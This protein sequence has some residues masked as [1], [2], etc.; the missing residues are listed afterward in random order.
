MQVYDLVLSWDWRY[1]EDFVMYVE[2][3]CRSRGLTFNQITRT[4]L[5]ETLTCLYSG[6]MTFRALLDRAADDL[7]FEPLRRFAQEHNLLRINPAEKSHWAEDK[8]TMHLELIQAGV[9]TPYTILLASF[10]HEPLLPAMDL[11]PLGTKFVVKP[12]VG[13]GGEGVRMN[14]T[15]LED[16]QRARLEYPDQKYLAQATIE[17]CN[18]AG[19]KAWFRVFY[20]H[21]DCI[22][23][24]WDPST[25][26]YASLKIDEEAVF[27]L[28]PLRTVTG[29]IARVCQLDW[30]STEIALTCDGQF[31]V[32][33][34]V[35]DGIDTRTQSKAADG[36]PDEILR[37]MAEKLVSMVNRQSDQESGVSQ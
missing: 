9:N 7:R 27:H 28:E 35:N 17:P 3:A 36:V 34:Y 31:V 10:I 29:Q 20:V 19:R 2:A 11:T 16:I 4:N 5:L 15:S 24:W 33:D 32:V 25:H 37:Y 21:G 1:D 23:C 14:A 22:A 13:G 30:F 18:L 26:I 8:A 12:A 6:Q